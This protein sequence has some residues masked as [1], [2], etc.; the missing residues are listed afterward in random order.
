MGIIGNHLQRIIFT[1]RARSVN[2]ARQKEEKNM[3]LGHEN[4]FHSLIGERVCWI[5]GQ[6]GSYK[7]ALA[8]RLAYEL[9]T[10]KYG[11][12]HLISNIP[13]VWSDK[14]TDIEIR[15]VK[16]LRTEDLHPYADTVAILDEGG[17][18][19]RYADD[20]D[21]LFTFL[22]KLNML[23]IV[24][25]K[26]EPHRTIRQLRAYKK[27]D[28]HNVGVD[29]MVYGWK[30]KGDEEDTIG[31]FTW[32]GCSE[33]YGIYD[34]DYAPVDSEGIDAW[35][36]DLKNKLTGGRYDRQRAKQAVTVQSVAGYGGDDV[37][38]E[39]ASIVEDLATERRAISVL[40]KRK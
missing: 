31:S 32:L 1:F 30:L 16:A 34:T 38:S 36:V 13:D 5:K 39:L 29:G 9:L 25:S 10:G 23:I 21:Q 20:V 28:L 18:F 22:R 6:L 17:L 2:E 33:I 7:T 11:Y 15:Y 3:L 40:K 19:I 26:R 35:M 4:F 24:P 27:Y 8:Y 12:R 37:S 14:L